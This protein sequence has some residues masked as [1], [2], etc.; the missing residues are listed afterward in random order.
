MSSF[1][2]SETSYP[3]NFSDYMFIGSMN[4]TLSSTPLG[5]QECPQQT[6]DFSRNLTAASPQGL[7]TMVSGPGYNS[8]G[9]AYPNVTS[10]PFKLYQNTN[11]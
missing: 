8:L 1:Y 6:M 10:V 3:T 5:A 11:Y 2:K 9:S 7:P 4:C